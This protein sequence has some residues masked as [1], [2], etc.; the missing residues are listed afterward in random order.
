[1]ISFDKVQLLHKIF[2]LSF[3]YYYYY[4]FLFY[5][6]FLLFFDFDLINL[7]YQNLLTLVQIKENYVIKFFLILHLIRK[8]FI[9]NDIFFFFFW[10][11]ILVKCSETVTHEL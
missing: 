3:Y 2:Y 8:R 1:M 6:Y 10:E 9:K 4:Y 11:K 5:L 7:I